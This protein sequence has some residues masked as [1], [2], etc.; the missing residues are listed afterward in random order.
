MCCIYHMVLWSVCS[1]H[2]PLKLSELHA[3]EGTQYLP[4]P[5]HPSCATM[6]LHILLFCS[7]PP[8]TQKKKNST[9]R[10]GLLHIFWLTLRLLGL[11]SEQ[12]HPQIQES[13]QTEEVRRVFGNILWLWVV[14]QASKSTTLP[15]RV[16]IIIK[17][18]VE[19]K[20][21]DLIEV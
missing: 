12:C 2:T 10:N 6:W 8:P 17:E 20:L 21:F 1:V 3:R 5:T 4:L 11:I 16:S 14:Y 18:K 9:A 15:C 19:I 13:W 7:P